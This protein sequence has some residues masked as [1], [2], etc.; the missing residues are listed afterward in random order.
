M[1]D[2]GLGHGDAVGEHR[3]EV[4]A[5]VQ[6]FAGGD[7]DGGGA[8]HGAEVLGELRKHGLFDEERQE[9]FEVGQHAAGHRPTEPAVE[10]QR[11]VAL[12]P[13]GIAN[14][15]HSVHDGVDRGGGGEWLQLAAGV[16]LDRRHALGDLLG[17]RLGQ[18]FGVS[19]PT[20][21]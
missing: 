7:G 17:G 5:G 21:P 2:V 8:H 18:L 20:Q 19:P 4:P 9:R 6:P 3:A 12:R 10:V 11:Q 13:D 14:R 15:G 16:Q 1:A